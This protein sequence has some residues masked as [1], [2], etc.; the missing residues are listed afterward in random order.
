MQWDGIMLWCMFGS[1]HEFDVPLTVC[2]HLQYTI[3]PAVLLTLILT[4]LLTRVDAYKI[5][6]LITV[7]ASVIAT[8]NVADNIKIAVIWTIPWDSYLIH[9]SIWTYPPDSIVGPT[10]FRIPAEEL[11]FFVIQTYITSLLYILLNKPTLFPI[12]LETRNNKYGGSPVS[13]RTMGQLLIG[14]VMLAHFMVNDKAN[15]YMRLILLWSGPVLLLL[16]S[17]AH[18]ALTRLPWSKVV[19]PI[20]I[21]TV[22][23]WI[24]DTLALQ[25]G[26]WAITSGTKWAFQPWP[27]MEIEEAVFFLLTNTLVIFGLIAFDNANAIIDAFP[28]QFPN[29][30]TAPTP[31]QMVLALLLPTS[32]YDSRRL[33]GLKESLALLRRKSRSFYLASSVFSGR[34]RIDL[35]LLYAYCRVADDLVD[36]AKSTG[37]AEQWIQKLLTFLDLTFQRRP[38]SEATAQKRAE[39]LALFPPSRKILLQLP[40]SRV[41]AQPLYDLLEG[42]RSDLQFSMVGKQFPIKTMSDLFLYAYRVASTVAILCVDLVYFHHPQSGSPD[43]LETKRKCISSAI[44]MG[45]ALQYINIAR[46]VVVDAQN[47]R[48]YLPTELLKA[49]GTTPEATIKFCGQIPAVTKVRREVLEEA[50]Q[51]YRDNVDAIEDLPVEARGGIRVAVEA[52]VEIGRFMMRNGFEGVDAHDGAGRKAT[53]PKWRRILLAWMGM[54][55]YGR[56]RKSRIR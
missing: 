37:E 31:Q 36:N 48:C 8:T 35:I 56:S 5:S 29:V 12:Y 1:R 51:I 54:A 53:V 7:R 55:G 46:D 52:Y 40:S 14:G 2:S 4:P 43:M 16:W 22:Y 15:T 39:T 20:A 24:V 11:F 42:F 25:K 27:G 32:M 3:P 28:S 41:S 33:Q 30:S 18:Q 23:L 6:F 9:H 19:L 17:L 44:A 47:G 38:Y 21:P 13:I 50:M 26:T 45:R 10:L 34:L 49:N